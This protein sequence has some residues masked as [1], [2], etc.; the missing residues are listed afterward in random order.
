MNDKKLSPGDVVLVEGEIRA[1]FGDDKD[2]YPI[3][4]VS[5]QPYVE[6]GAE[7]VEDAKVPPVSSDELVKDLAVLV[8][9]HGIA[10]VLRAAADLIDPA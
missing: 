4:T 6:K 1:P 10:G 3:D 9:E 5:C 2:I 7:S 8:K